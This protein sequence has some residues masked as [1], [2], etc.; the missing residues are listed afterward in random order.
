MLCLFLD[1]G[2]SENPCS[3][4]FAGPTPFSE[5]E[6]IALRDF[7]SARS[8]EIKIYLSFHSFGQYVLFPYGHT[9]QEVSP[10]HE[11]MVCFLN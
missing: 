6:T 3:E 7:V 5:P 2:A 9:A 11:L 8:S 4:T 1:G 10:H